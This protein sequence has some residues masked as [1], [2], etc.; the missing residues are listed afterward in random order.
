MGD[1]VS[2]QLSTSVNSSEKTENQVTLTGHKE[3]SPSP[4][5]RPRSF[6]T[7]AHQDLE[8]L[9]YPPVAFLCYEHLKQ[10]REAVYDVMC[11]TD[12]I[13]KIDVLLPSVENKEQ[14]LIL[15]RARRL[16][17][18][19]ITQAEERYTEF[20]AVVPP[21]EE[22]S[23]GVPTPKSTNPY[24]K[25][26]KTKLYLRNHLAALTKEYIEELEKMEFRLDD[27][28]KKYL[29]LNELGS[30]PQTDDILDSLRARRMTEKRN[31]RDRIIRLKIPL[32]YAV[33]D[34]VPSSNEDV[35]AF[36]D[37]YEY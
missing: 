24:D 32:L 34:L 9:G 29:T 8:K 10:L 16:I 35:G 23:E 11:Y 22:S 18:T 36:D 1:T 6:P 27:L 5:K 12:H 30:I 17:S 2:S 19:W 20:L 25:T 26:W 31:Y 28:D 13:N 37:A 3:D 15:R 21:F 33:V 4:A 7:V 14:H